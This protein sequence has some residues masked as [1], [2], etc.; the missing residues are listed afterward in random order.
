MRGPHVPPSGSTGVEDARV[1]RTEDIDARW[2][3]VF[4]AARAAFPSLPLTMATFVAYASARA[5]DRPPADLPAADLYLACACAHRIPGSVEAFERTILAQMPA[6]L[7]RLKPGAA[8]VDEVRQ[9]IL[10][11][12]F[13]PS[14]DAPPRITEYAGRGS[15]AGWVRIASVRAALNLKRKRSEKPYDSFDAL[16]AQLPPVGKDPELDILRVRYL[17]DVKGALEAAFRTL[18]PDLRLMLRLHSVQSLQGE[19]IARILRVNRSTVMRNL[20]RAREQLLAETQRTLRGRLKITDSECST[21]VRLVR[22][23]LAVS[24]PRL[25]AASGG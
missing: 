19:E 7:S 11:R 3:A 6:F 25:L 23:E 14:G 12:L 1:A 4:D 20:A 10:T 17:D 22:S 24:L 18:P 13:V 9:E 8:F 15:L 16:E 2:Q 21:I 5:G